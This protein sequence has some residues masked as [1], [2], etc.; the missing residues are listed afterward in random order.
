MSLSSVSLRA[1]D[2][3]SMPNASSV[4]T[5]YPPSLFPPAQVAACLHADLS[6]ISDSTRTSART[7]SAF[8]NELFPLF[9]LALPHVDPRCELGERRALTGRLVLQV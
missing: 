4:T 1:S 3:F 6:P 9:L 5:F 7:V 2:I 8:L